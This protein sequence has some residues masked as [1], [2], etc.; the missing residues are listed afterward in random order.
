MNSERK[1]VGE[2][3]DLEWVWGELIIQIPATHAH[4]G[5]YAVEDEFRGDIYNDPEGDGNYKSYRVVGETGEKKLPTY[6][7]IEEE[8]TSGS[9]CCPMNS[10]TMLLE[11]VCAEE[12]IKVKF[13]LHEHALYRDQMDRQLYDYCLDRRD[14][15]QSGDRPHHHAYERVDFEFRATVPRLQVQV[16]NVPRGIRL[17]QHEAVL[18]HTH[19][20]PMG[21][22]FFQHEAA[23]E[24]TY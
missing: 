14:I 9:E 10:E 2:Q 23:L 6:V 18:E 21:I 17:F 15:P 3:E 1:L 19:G 7:Y 12:R 13:E 22:R 11:W 5:Y 4:P 20:A 8:E 16:D 24:H